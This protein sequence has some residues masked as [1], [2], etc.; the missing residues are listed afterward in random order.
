[1][2]CHLIGSVINA[3]IRL[4]LLDQGNKAINSLGIYSRIYIFF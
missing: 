3:V 2:S 1:M 4:V